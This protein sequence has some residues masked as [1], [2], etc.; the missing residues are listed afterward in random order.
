MACFPSFILFLPTRGPTIASDCAQNSPAE[1]YCPCIGR[2]PRDIAVKAETNFRRG[3]SAGKM[4]SP[5][6]TFIISKFPLSC[7]PSSSRIITRVSRFTALTRPQIPLT[8]YLISRWSPKLSLLCL[9]SLPPS[10]DSSLDSPR[11]TIASARWSSVKMATIPRPTPA[12]KVPL[13]KRHAVP[14][15]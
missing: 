5:I 8:S 10:M 4:A 13:A 12:A 3:S 2:P 1:A 9:S 6:Y 11:W 15:R 14:V 7:F